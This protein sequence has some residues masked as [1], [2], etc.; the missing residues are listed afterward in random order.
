[1]RASQTCAQHAACMP[2][3][4]FIAQWSHVLACL[5]DGARSWCVRD[6]LTASTRSVSAGSDASH[7]RA[8]TLPDRDLAMHLDLVPR[9]Y[10]KK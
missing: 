7:Q 5:C 9:A 1:M 4:L 6:L 2:P 3:A 8:A 10:E